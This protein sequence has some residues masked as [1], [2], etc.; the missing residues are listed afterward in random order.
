M[1]QDGL[2][3]DLCEV[4]AMADIDRHFAR[5]LVEFGASPATSLAAAVVSA[6]CV[7]IGAVLADVMS[8]AFGL[9]KQVFVALG[10]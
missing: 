9:G 10:I 7:P 5:L 1:N 4:G 3:A 8:H 6:M 2:L